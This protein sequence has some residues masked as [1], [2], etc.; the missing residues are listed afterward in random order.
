MI[1]LFLNFLNQKGIEYRVTNGY[2]EII[3]PRNEA[4]D[5]DILISK[6]N[7]LKIDE[8]VHYFSEQG[9]FQVVQMYHQD[10]YARNYFLYDP[11]KHSLLNLDLYGELSRLGTRIL[12]EKEVF[13][14]HVKFKHISILRPEQEF[15]QYLVKKID[16]GSISFNA[17]E[18][19]NSLFD[20]SKQ[21]CGTYLCSFFKDT[22]NE[23]SAIFERSDLASFIDNVNRFKEDFKNNPKT[24]K[25]PFVFK[26]VRLAKRV[27]HPTGIAIGFL[28]P[29]GSGKS[30]VIELLNKRILPFRR[31]D[32]FHLKPILQDVNK[33]NQVVTNPHGSTPYS[34]VTSFGKLLF[35]IYQYNLGW[36]RNV[37]RLKIKSSLIIFDRYF[38]DMLVDYKRY[39][40]GASITIAKKCRYLI[41]RP[42]LYFVLTAE[43]E[44]ILN[45]KQEVAPDELK[46]QIE[47][48]R[49][50]VD[51]KQYVGI[52]VSREP[53]IIVDEI[54]DILMK[55]MNE[56]Y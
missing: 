50:L 46:R 7:F 6:K 37:T 21:A 55:R 11:K 35:F 1:E 17:F 28:G 47:G 8:T 14:S 32:Y 49:S 39:R 41:P 52:D 25:E 56:R 34:K 20:V 38:D 54:V 42:A 15:I 16:K 27:Y 13:E 51:N 23:L 3:A 2:E 48:Y 22:A 36:I 5:F 9:N 31:T 29:D 43:S 19:L 40:Y 45:R 30:T 26:S 53:H 24:A 18:K 12:N 4:S 44:I 10:R 33:V